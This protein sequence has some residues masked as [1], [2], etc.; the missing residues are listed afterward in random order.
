[1]IVNLHISPYKEANRFN[2]DP[3]RPRKL[4][5]H[6]HEIRRLIGKVEGKGLTLIPLQLYFRSGFAK[7]QIGL[8][9][10]RRHYDKREKLKRQT[11]LREAKREMEEVR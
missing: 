1:M 3:L 9:K 6:R 10:G 11:Q 8:A 7:V 2:V 5:L 4:L